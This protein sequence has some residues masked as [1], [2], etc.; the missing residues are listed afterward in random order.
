MRLYA[1]SLV[2]IALALTLGV[3]PQPQVLA[4]NGLAMVDA[5]TPLA[6]PMTIAAAWDTAMARSYGLELARQARGSGASVAAVPLDRFGSE[7]LLS[8]RI[9]A[10]LVRAM[11]HAGVIAAAFPGTGH[12]SVRALREAEWPPL[13]SAI[14]DGGVGAVTCVLRDGSTASFCQNRTALATML[15][16]DVRFEGFVIGTSGELASTSRVARTVKR[17]RAHAQRPPKVDGDT[18][19]RRFVQNGA[20]LLRND[21]SVLPFDPKTLTTLG[22][23]GADA[24]TLAALRAALPNTRVVEIGASDPGAAAAA[25]KTVRA[26]AIVFGANE[27]AGEGDLVRAVAAA[28]PQTAVVLEREPADA[29]RWAAA[30]PALLL[31]WNP[32]P[33]TPLAVAN[34]LAGLVAPSGHLPAPLPGVGGMTGFPLGAGLSYTTFAYSELRVAYVRGA[35]P[36]TIS[37]VVRNTGKRS[38]TAVPQLY[39][40]L[41]PG[42]QE[43]DTR[44]AGFMRVALASGRSRRVS[45]PLTVHSFAYWSPVYHAWFV[46]PG[47]Y[48]AEAGASQ[49]EAALT[50]TVRIVA[51]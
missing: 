11:Q 24:A 27:S 40:R 18:L 2:L 37:F 21:G 34:L 5:S 19:S 38:G 9:A 30:A 29:P 39:L 14:V 16:R 10:T 3:S 20:V 41:P 32:A 35:H 31:A 17:I 36:V 26:C 7:A 51:R 42:A 46:A 49:A 50:G 22:A 48:R 1:R 45:F 15:A 4:H 13:R 12:G 43:P 47:S 28:N 33:G 25:A 44:L 23:I 8:Q 6:S